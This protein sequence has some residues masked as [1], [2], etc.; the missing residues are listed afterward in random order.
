M[1]AADQLEEGQVG[2]IRF[3]CNI[4]HASRDV[5]VKIQVKEGCNVLMYNNKYSLAYFH[6]SRKQKNY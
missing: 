3:E 5:K 4:V 6:Y 2:F 1:F